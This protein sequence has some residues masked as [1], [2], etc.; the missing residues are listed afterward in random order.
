[1]AK[2]GWPKCKASVLGLEMIDG[3]N[4]HNLSCGCISLWCLFLMIYRVFKPSIHSCWPR[5]T[6]FWF[7]I[8]SVGESWSLAAPKLTVF[9]L[10]CLCERLLLERITSIHLFSARSPLG[11]PACKFRL[12]SQVCTFHSRRSYP[13]TP[14]PYHAHKKGHRCFLHLSLKSLYTL[15]I[16]DHPLC[17]A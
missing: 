16:L 6:D 15:E 7:G 8:N 3:S 14:R 10:I 9:H 11:T 17:K 1:M 2:L 4:N 13:R 12:Q 5:L